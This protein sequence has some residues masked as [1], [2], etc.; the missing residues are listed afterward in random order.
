MTKNP[1]KKYIS[2]RTLSQSP[3]PKAKTFTRTKGELQ[4]V[5]QKHAA[6]RL[7]YDFRLEVGGV[8]KSWAVPKGP[9]M[10]PSVKRLAIRVEDHPY[11]YRNFEGVIPSGYG[12]GAVMIWDRGTYHVDGVT[13]KE[14]E[15]LIQEGL[16]KGAIHFTLNGDK[17]QGR[18]SLVKLKKEG[19]EKEEW[20][21]VKSKD[22]FSTPSDIT[23]KD[24]SAVSAKT[25]EE[26][27]G[28][29]VSKNEP[30]LSRNPGPSGPSE[31]S[32]ANTFQNPYRAKNPE[33]FQGRLLQGI[34]AKKPSLLKPMLATLIDEPFNDPAWIFEIKW[35]GF[36][37][38]AELQG[39]HVSIYSRNQLSFNERFPIILRDLAQL[40]LDAIVDGEIVVLDQEGKSHFQMLQNHQTEKNTYF[41][42]FDI[43]YLN[44]RDLRTLPLVKRKSLLKSV[45]KKNSHVRYLEDVDTQGVKFFN[46]CKKKGLEGIIGKKKEGL[47]E[48]GQRSKVWVKIKADLRQ[49]VVICGFTEPRRSRKN[50][51]ALI[52]GV[53]KSGVLQFA[54]HVGGGFSEKQLE[55]I[56]KL[57]GTVI[58]EKCP[59]KSPPKTN[60]AVT[61]V[62]PHFLCEVKFKE[63]TQAGTMRMPIFLGMRADKAASAVTREKKQPTTK[64]VKHQTHPLGKYDFITHQD[65]LYWEEEKIT[66]GDL[67]AYYA[68]IAPYI[69]PYLKDRPESLR[70]YPNGVTHQNFFQKNMVTYPEWLE[71]I[72]VEHHDKTVNYMV[73][74]DVKS[75]LYAVNLGCI[76]IHPWF[77]RIQSLS[78]PDF[79][80]F[81]LDPEKIPF[82]A[83]VE[84]AHVFHALLT[85][86][87]VP[88][89][90]KTSGSRGLHICIPLSAKY[91]YEQAKQFAVLIATLVHRQL[92]EITS[93]ERSP[94]KRQNKVYL[95]CYQNNYGQTLAAPYS[96]RAKPGGLVS[97]PLEWSEIQKG[98]TPSDYT[99]FNTLERVKQKG[100]IFKPLLQKGINLEKVLKLL[101]KL[102]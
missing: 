26:I 101:Q 95:D 38:L 67:L 18:F 59:F 25:L 84:T 37:A 56:K 44:G 92:P 53:Y 69:L 17:L 42:V 9:S 5:I 10:D 98:M 73:I 29:V 43:L 4:F 89:Y 50:F 78:N 74:Q 71:T 23:Q 63:W 66:K 2:K 46:L 45:L 62:K 54:G 58:T 28:K 72:E 15:K 77:S 32:H 34:K 85:Q 76:E 24:R 16:K 60:T 12:A 81:D 70:R 82:D 65:K 75:L 27:S 20:L 11:A 30:A 41:Y 83:V 35:D 3:E 52:I 80:V 55:D 93:L 1:L 31:A 86:L 87:K 51:G 21:L 90:C 79:L 14:A 19:P 48:T 91:P 6:S 22:A 68:A 7:H 64:T 33:A 13:G 88:S 39:S 94:K 40:D 57:L 96:V 102:L 100:D 47:Y 49:E 99:L 97:T 61:W 8:L 36:R